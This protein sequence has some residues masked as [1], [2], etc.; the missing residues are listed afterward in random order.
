MAIENEALEALRPLIEGIKSGDI[1]NPHMPI[2]KFVHESE[3]VKACAIKDA[4]HFVKIRY[5][6]T[7]GC[8]RLGQATGALRETQRLWL[9]E[10][11]LGGEAEV[12]WLSQRDNGYA[13][14]GEVQ[15]Y[16]NHILRRGKAGPDHAARL[17]AIRKGTGHA[18]MIEDLGAL[19][20]MALELSS[21]LAE[22]GY[23]AD[24]IT[25]LRDLHNLLNNVYGTVS[26]SRA[27]RSPALILRNRAYVFALRLL[28]EI[29]DSARLAMRDMPELLAKYASP[30]IG[31]SAD[32]AEDPPA[33][34]P[35]PGPHTSPTSTGA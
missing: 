17:K 3:R 22:L 32:D 14:R 7:A 29:K 30:T 12:T 13:L 26:A 25:A 16:I 21:E 23:G 11:A 6:V 10:N 5:D 9:V 18:D 1:R 34:P 15:D 8:A 33:P 20:D 24:K 31:G 28:N 4:P 27:G 35:G 2:D 19:A